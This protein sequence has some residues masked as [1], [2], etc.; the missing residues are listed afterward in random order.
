[1]MEV[2]NR[3]TDKPSWGTKVFNHGLVQK[4]KIEILAMPNQDV[5]E[6]MFDWVRGPEN[7]SFLD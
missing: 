1:M 4:W 7:G 6:R 2:M 3:L 5:S